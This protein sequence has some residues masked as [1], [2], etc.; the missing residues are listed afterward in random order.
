MRQ[1]ALAVTIAACLITACA[2]GQS[3]PEIGES[4][5]YQYVPEYTDPK[6]AQYVYDLYHGGWELRGNHEDCAS[7]AQLL[8]AQSE[9]FG[10]AREGLK[11]TAIRLKREG[12]QGA[13]KY[14][15]GYFV[16]LLYEDWRS[17]V[18]KFSQEDLK[19][20]PPI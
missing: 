4:D 9:Y 1:I 10:D 7:L 19:A 12:A 5:V 6:A 3:Q 2:T 16:S 13:E 14:T 11:Q 17:C 15:A 20:P 18:N 8:A